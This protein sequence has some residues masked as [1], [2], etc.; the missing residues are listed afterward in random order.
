MISAERVRDI[1]YSLKF[2]FNN[3]YD[4]LK[5]NFVLKHQNIEDSKL[6]H[7]RGLSLKLQTEEKV[8]GF[9]ISNFSE[10]FLNENE[11]PRYITDINS[12]KNNIVWM[13]W[14]GR[15]S[16]LKNLYNEELIKYEIDDLISIKDK[17]VQPKIVSL[18]L[19]KQIS[20]ETIALLCYKYNSE[21]DKW[22]KESQDNIFLPKILDFY[23]KYTRLMIYYLK[24]VK[25][26]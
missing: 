4:A 11:Y 18:W 22:L 10:H 6:L 8:L 15:L 2:Y 9:F 25:K 16:N 19:K 17:F 20:I 26:K 23:K 24:E 14:Q 7:F 5:Y 12:K 3:D 21:F 13:K 1:F